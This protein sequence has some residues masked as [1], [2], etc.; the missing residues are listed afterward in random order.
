M[1][2]TKF[3]VMVALAALLVPA[4]LA[5][6]GKFE[7]LFVRAD[8]PPNGDGASWATA[9]DSLQDAITA[10][11][12]GK[13]SSPEVWVARGTYTPTALAVPGVPRSATFRV[14]FNT[15]LLGGFW[16]DENEFG[17]VPPITERRYETILTGD[18]LGDDNP[19]RGETPFD[20]NAFHVVTFNDSNGEIDGFT[21]RAGQA[22][23][24]SPQ[25]VGAGVYIIGPDANVVI[26]NCSI[27]ENFGVS[28]GAGVYANSGLLRIE[29][30]FIKDNFSTTGDGAGVFSGANGLVVV[31]SAFY[32]NITVGAS[33]R[34]GGLFCGGPFNTVTNSTFVRNSS[35]NGGGGI[36]AFSPSLIVRNSILWRNFG[37]DTTTELQQVDGN[38]VAVST[39]CIEGLA[40]F[41]GGNGNIGLNPKLLPVDR[42]SDNQW[43]TGDDIPGHIIMPDS[44]CA[45]AGDNSVDIDELS[46][47]VQPLPT[48]E[49]RGLQRIVDCNDSM[50]P[51]MV[52]MG[53]TE[54]QPGEPVYWIR[55][56][57]GSWFSTSAWLGLMPAQGCTGARFES[58]DQFIVCDV[59]IPGKLLVNPASID[60]NNAF[61][62]IFPE[63]LS[64]VDVTGDFAGVDGFIRVENG[65][66]GFIADP[67]AGGFG[68][69]G[70]LIVGEEATAAFALDGFNLFAEEARIGGDGSVATIGSFTSL[71][72]TGPVHVAPR[73]DEAAHLQ[74][75]SSALVQAGAA[76]VIGGAGEGSLTV[77]G[78]LTALSLLIG[79]APGGQGDVAVEPGASVSLTTNIE[80]GTESGGVG[81]LLIHSPDTL[82]ALVTAV[83]PGS[84]VWGDGDLASDLINRGVVSPGLGDN[85]AGDEIVVYGAY[86]QERLPGQNAANSGSLIIDVED[87]DGFAILDRLLVDGSAVLGGGLFLRP[88]DGFSPAPGLFQGPVLQAA[89]LANTFDVVFTPVLA[90][91]R[92]LRVR[93]ENG[94]NVTLYVDTIF[95]SAGF[96]DG[97]TIPIEPGSSASAAAVGNF[98]GDAFLDLAVTLPND[99]NQIPGCVLILINQGNVGEE[100][101]GYSIAQC[102]TVGLDPSSVATGDFNG[103]GFTDVIVSNRMSDTVTALR[104]DGMGDFSFF[105]P[106]TLPVGAVPVDIAV[107]DL[108][109]DS[110][111]DIVTANQ[112]DNGVTILLGTGGGMFGP[113]D[114]E[115]TGLEPSALIIDNFSPAPGLEIAVTNK[116]D[117]TIAI[118]E[119]AGLFA[120]RTT[121]T[122]PVGNGSLPDDIDSG[123]VDGDKDIDIVASD[124]STGQSPT[125]SGGS[126][127]VLRRDPTSNT[128]FAAPV[129]VPV[130]AMPTSVALTDTDGDGD[131]DIAVVAQDEMRGGGDIVQLV[132]NDFVPQDGQLVFAQWIGVPQEND[133]NFVLPADVNN[134]ALDDLITLNTIVGGMLRGVSTSEVDVLLNAYEPPVQGDANGDGM[135]DMFDLN[136]ILA[137]YNQGGIGIPGDLDGDDYVGFSDLNLLLGNFNNVGGG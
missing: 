6:A 56:D 126:V 11:E 34:G 2:R 16:G 99:D 102:I 137:N 55:T 60:V 108:N 69:T 81:T 49:L 57:A 70:A 10:I 125:G 133:P 80:V 79:A 21:I 3:T 116:G 13:F 68:T 62:N 134:D 48:T 123:D 19:G 83:A 92:F 24:P 33:A 129:H 78:N 93:Y 104:N 136:V 53:A 111:L 7:R 32:A 120:V 106:L 97:D 128:G 132:R 101:Q 28:H 1:L 94:Q 107:G 54:V 76:A 84:L 23:S 74:I 135:A 65:V 52:D 30:C 17:P 109:D 29:S 51:A 89:S 36:H 127:A 95:D 41:Y 77:E 5:Q 98:N 22:T 119:N 131:L 103:D 12:F 38:F 86:V 20:D 112:A 64:G 71:T 67:K 46:P 82:A 45:N 96:E 47:G 9:F 100:W 58:I 59:Q 72:I 90:D 42:G 35:N 14:P 4:S 31:N 66:L 40:T 110:F 15:T 114:A 44:P 61:I 91:G 39:S 88:V 113:P 130:G 50:P 122:V 18:L 25:M 27:I 8:A 85:Y 87:T 26:R 75:E 115:P 37:G 117:G 105:P 63:F 121:S 124:Q 73:I 118:I 43:N